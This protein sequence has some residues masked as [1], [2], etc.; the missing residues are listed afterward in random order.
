MLAGM[1]HADPLAMMAKLVLIK[2][3]DELKLRSK[4]WRLLKRAAGEVAR[5]VPRK[6]RPALSA[7][8]DHDSVRAGA[9]ERGVGVVAG[10]DVAVYPHRDRHRPLHGPHSRPVR[11]PLPQLAHPPP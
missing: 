3:A 5:D 4:P 10:P 2:H 8:A 7:A 9:C 11:A 6:P 1:L